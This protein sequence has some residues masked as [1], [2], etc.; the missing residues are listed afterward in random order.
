MREAEY[1][2]SMGMHWTIVLECSVLVEVLWYREAHVN[3]ESQDEF[4]SEAV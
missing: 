4:S 2:S 1:P 3:R